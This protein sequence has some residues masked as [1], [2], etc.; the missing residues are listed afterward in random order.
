MIG[1]G[2]SPQC[3]QAWNERYVT[4]TVKIG[5]MSTLMFSKTLFS[6]GWLLFCASSTAFAPTSVHRRPSLIALRFSSSRLP[7]PDEWISLSSDS[8]D[9][10]TGRNLY[11]RLGIEAR[12]SIVHYSDRFAV[13]AHGTEPDP[14]IHYAN[15]A[16]LELF[17][18]SEKEIYQI[19]SRVT[20]PEHV[21]R[22]HDDVLELP[23]HDDFW[24]I[25]RAM[26]QR[27]SGELFESDN[28]LVFC[29]YDED[30]KWIGQ[31]TVYDLDQVHLVDH[32]LDD[33][34]SIDLLEQDRRDNYGE[35]R[36]PSDH[37]RLAF[38]DEMRNRLA[39]EDNMRDRSDH[40]RDYNGS[41]RRDRSDSR[42]EYNESGMRD[43]STSRMEYNG[44]DMR[45]RSDH[46]IEYNGGDMRDFDMYQ[47]DYEEVDEPSGSGLEQ[48]ARK[49][50]AIV[51]YMETAELFLEDIDRAEQDGVDVAVIAEM[52]ELLEST[53]DHL[54]MLQ[55]ELEDIRRRYP[56]VRIENLLPEPQPV[57]NDRMPPE[58]QSNRREQVIYDT[59]SVY[60]DHARKDRMLPESSRSTRRD[61]VIYDSHSV[62]S[63]RLPPPGMGG[64]MFPS[65]SMPRMS[66]G[67]G[68]LQT[69]RLSPR[70][71]EQ[72]MS[73]SPNK[74]RDPSAAADWTRSP[75]RSQQEVQSQRMGPRPKLPRMVDDDWSQRLRDEEIAVLDQ[76]SL[77]KSGLFLPWSNDDAERLSME[78]EQPQS[79]LFRDPEGFLSLA[80]RQSKQFAKW[81]RPSE[82]VQMRL[83]SRLIQ[84]P[85]EISVVNRIT[86]H[87]IRQHFVSD[88]SFMA[89]LCVCADIEERFQKPL[90]SGI[91]YP[92]TS[93]GYP[94]Y[95][96]NGKYMV[97]F[98]FNGGPRCV[99]IDDYLPVDKDG[100]LL[101]SDSTGSQSDEFELWV[102]LIEKAYMKLCGGYDHPGSNA[103]ID[104]YSLT[105]WIPEQVHFPDNPYQVRDFESDPEDA[106]D[107]ITKASVHGD[108]LFTVSTPEGAKEEEVNEKTGLVSG[109]A[110][111]VLDFVETR[112]GERLLQLKNPWARQS[113]KGR[114]S[115]QDFETWSDSALC[116]E[117]GYEPTQAAEQ[118]EDHGVF[119]ISWND[120]LHHFKNFYL[121]WDP[122]RFPNRATVH[123]LWPRDQGPD[124]DTYN[125]GDN[126]QY[127]LSL[128]EQAIKNRATIW[129]LIS[130][131]VK[132]VELDRSEV[133]LCCSVLPQ[134]SSC[135]ADH[136]CRRTLSRSMST[137]TMTIGGD[138][139]TL[140][141]AVA[142]S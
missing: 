58:P 7:D 106:W 59:H 36:D 97:K 26:R 89:G 64:R 34:R 115:N 117:I 98:W 87:T 75:T 55:D 46:R 85:Q 54:H 22:A 42:M 57:R 18:Y 86:P 111:A 44:G 60:A 21:A 94:M 92:Q 91:L 52:R 41:D 79:A 63:D 93:D 120:V 136:L 110:Y 53:L 48:A 123:G 31:T 74:M 29:V 47:R 99:V 127:V 6:V 28:V 80:P 11:E 15:Q 43:R 139:I 17:D 116:N 102:C 134:C 88:C 112:F 30:G 138:C 45:D 133:R 135:L 109:H 73:S 39:F 61:E 19:P 96:P 37:D 35:M 95:N 105:G 40:G 10:L 82:I 103:G 5:S 141:R 56:E 130:R 66:Q 27:R 124:E 122:S 76:S 8:L 101:C 131:H 129:I 125:I 24:L 72:R 1:V 16:A 113:W 132:M 128:S 2:P 62:H 84:R 140:A 51:M 3:L 13:V 14:M 100:N 71:P 137:E 119:W 114:Y 68:S 107:R 9:R 142:A 50:E 33:N 65:Q 20:A 70:R 12:P 118:G 108:C 49:A 69:E 78:A 25:P 38:D 126:P 81:A 4:N 90:V 121:F 83:D 23:V 104:L 32:R 67:G 77:I